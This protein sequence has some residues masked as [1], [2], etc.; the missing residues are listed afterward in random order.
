MP[1]TPPG[2]I[3]FLEFG[4]RF[5]GRSEWFYWGVAYV[6]RTSPVYRISIYDACTLNIE[7][8]FSDGLNPTQDTPTALRRISV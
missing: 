6:G 1:H 3:H 5:V 7:Y 2:Y 8:Q 4:L